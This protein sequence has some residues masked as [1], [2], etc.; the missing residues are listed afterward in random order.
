M[1]LKHS[2]YFR[3]AMILGFLPPT[4]EFKLVGIKSI[5]SVDGGVAESSPRGILVMPVPQTDRLSITLNDA[6]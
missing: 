4:L 2:V 1:E 5:A 3:V 6:I